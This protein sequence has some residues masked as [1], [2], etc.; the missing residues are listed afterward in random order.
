[1]RCLEK[2]YEAL[3]IRSSYLKR[4]KTISC[5]FCALQ[6]DKIDYKILLKEKKLAYFEFSSFNATK[7]IVCH[8]CLHRYICQLSDNPNA[9]ILHIKDGKNILKCKVYCNQDAGLEDLELGNISE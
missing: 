4:R 9:K 1:M 3:L 5:A 7:P 2:M 8:D 6:Y